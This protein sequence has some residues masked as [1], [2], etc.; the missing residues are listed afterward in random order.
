[1]RA[2][3]RCRGRPVIVELDVRRLQAGFY[4]Y[5]A[6]NGG[7]ELYTD[8]GF[9]SIA[10]ALRSASDI[11]GDIRGF[12]VCYGGVVVGTYPVQELHESAEVVAAHAVRT[13]SAFGHH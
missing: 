6:S 9:S 4:E 2:V 3:N 8:A 5:R 1:M 13:A 11:T 7:H 12:E 10:D